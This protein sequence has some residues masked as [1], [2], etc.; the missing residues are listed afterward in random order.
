MGVGRSRLLKRLREADRYGRFA[1][2]NCDLPGVN[3]DEVK[4]HSKVMVVDDRLLRVGSSNLSNRSLGLASE[5]D[6]SIEADG[7]PDTASAI[8]RFRH[9]LLAEPLQTHPE[10]VAAE[11]NHPG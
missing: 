11:E 9:P 4:I 6:L 10:R 2:F 3:R 5:C 7:R 1:V 8:F